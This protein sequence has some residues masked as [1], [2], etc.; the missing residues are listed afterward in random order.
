MTVEV[1]EFLSPRI[2]SGNTVTVGLPTIIVKVTLRAIAELV[3]WTVMLK[4]SE[5]HSGPVVIVR[6]VV[7][8]SPCMS[9]RGVGGPKL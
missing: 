9:I 2:G 4:A 3:A 6:L 1:V 7:F 8:E 5:G